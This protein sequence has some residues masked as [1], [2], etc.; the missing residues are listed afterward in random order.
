MKYSFVN[1]GQW[2]RAGPVSI[3]TLTH[4]IDGNVLDY[5]VGNA[6]GGLG[7]DSGEGA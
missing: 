6:Y 7:F 3:M 1:G 5:R 2:L 4:Q